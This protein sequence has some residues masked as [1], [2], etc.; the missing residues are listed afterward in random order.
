MSANSRQ[1][2]YDRIRKS[3]KDEVILEEMQRLGFWPSSEGKPSGSEALI[4]R[5]G[6]LERE[7]RQLMSTQRMMQNPEAALVMMRKQR[8]EESKQRRIDNKKRRLQEKY[9]RALQWHQRRETDIVFLGNEV[10]HHL[11]EVDA[12]SERLKKFQLPPLD[13]ALALAG[14]MGISLS[15]LRFL[16]Y[17]REVSTISHYQRFIIAKKSGG[18]RH[19]S[20]PMPRL[21]RAQ[22]WILDNILEKIDI[23]DAAHGFRRQRSI[24]TN[25]NPHVGSYLVMNCDLQDFFPTFH[26][27]RIKGLFKSLGYS[28]QLATLLALLCSEP[29]Q[30]EVE[31]DD[32][33]YHV[34]I[35]ERRLP[36][37]APTSPAI[38]NIIC[39][40]L[41]ARMAGAAKSLGFTYTRYAD[42]MT[43]SCAK[44]MGK[45]LA[46]M[47]FRMK[48]ILQDEGLVLHPK[49]TRVMRVGQK[50]EVTGIVVNQKPSLDRK[51]LRRFRATLQQI[52]R[53]GPEGKSWGNSPHVLSAI[54]GYAHYVAMVDPE[55]GRKFVEQ[56]RRI[57]KQYAR[58]LENGRPAP[59]NNQQFRLAAAQGNTPREPW[60]IPQEKPLPQLQTLPEKK[61]KSTLRADTGVIVEEA[62]QQAG[63]ERARGSTPRARAW[64]LW[65]R[66]KGA[67]WVLLLIYILGRMLTSGNSFAITIATIFIVLFFIGLFTDDK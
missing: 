29:E 59:L 65:Q 4:K 67:L 14:A 60:W 51:T 5:Q 40:R 11:N 31:L 3:S 13:N 28:P 53:F 66:V 15:E 12:N 34:N 30:A 27:A 7:L 36:Q 62:L 45:N 48:A 61:P 1:Q 38:S 42:D 19:I 21:K 41:D 26:Y 57:F 9:D 18:E 63:M 46:K 35:G 32:R 16:C 33:R 17:N 55:K 6:E 8:M 54:K 25:A 37:G 24:V 56:V 20:A 43:F 50:Q 47:Q 22:Y 58:P 64:M 2:L 23:H 52:E 44:P 10:S 39:R 49:K